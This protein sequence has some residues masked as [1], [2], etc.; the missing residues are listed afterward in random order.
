VTFP[1]GRD[2]LST[3]PVPTGSP[4]AAQTIGISRVACLAAA[5]AG[6]NQGHDYI[7]FDAHQFR[8]Q[9][10]KAVDLSFVGT[11]F[12]MNVL[13]IDVTEVAQCLRK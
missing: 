5:A 1:P 4:Q 3:S 2:R 12:E 8:C 6:V 11:E 10:W 7:D 13:S 9:S